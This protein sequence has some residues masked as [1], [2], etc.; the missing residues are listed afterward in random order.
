M[1][2]LFAA[3]Y[4]FLAL[5]VSRTLVAA[6]APPNNPARQT[7]AGNTNIHHDAYGK[8]T[9]DCHGRVVEVVDPIGSVTTYTYGA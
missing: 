9:Y 2:A 1:Q 5:P 4:G 7:I 8:V 6:S 3:F